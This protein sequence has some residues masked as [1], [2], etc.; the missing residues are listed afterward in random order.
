MKFKFFAMLVVATSFF[1]GCGDSGHKV[2][3][4]EKF[5]PHTKPAGVGKGVGHDSR[6]GTAAD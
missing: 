5:M 2:T 4:P 6:S 3:A 1:V